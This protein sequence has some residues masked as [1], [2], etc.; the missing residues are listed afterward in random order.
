MDIPKER[1]V[2]RLIFWE[3]LALLMGCTIMFLISINYIA[4]GVM[5]CLVLLA[6]WYYDSWL[7]DLE[8][9]LQPAIFCMVTAGALSCFVI[10]IAKCTSYTGLVAFLLPIA[11]IIAFV[12]TMFFAFGGFMHAQH[13]VENYIRDGSTKNAYLKVYGSIVLELWLLVFLALCAF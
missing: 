5:G 11:G 10:I 1:T 8:W 13:C 9:E 6:F 4:G 12:A 2:G 7:G 3:T